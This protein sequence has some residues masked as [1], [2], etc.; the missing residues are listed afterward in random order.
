VS[1]KSKKRLV[2]YIKNQEEHHHKIPFLSEYQSLLKENE[3]Q[4]DPKYLL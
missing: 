1:I 4:F 3:V 2:E